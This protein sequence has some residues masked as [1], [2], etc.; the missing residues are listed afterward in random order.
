ML[1]IKRPDLAKLYDQKVGMQIY[2]FAPSGLKVG[3][4]LLC[5][6]HCSGA[7]ARDTKTDTGFHKI[8][9]LNKCTNKILKGL[10]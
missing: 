6:L 7:Y 8:D 4:R 9:L 3:V 5:L 1:Y 2:T 10:S